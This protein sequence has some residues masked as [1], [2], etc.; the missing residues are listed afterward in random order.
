MEYCRETCRRE[1]N[2][3]KEINGVLPRNLEERGE[4]F[5]KKKWSGV[6]EHD[7]QE[8]PGGERSKGSKGR[9]GV[10]SRNMI[11]AET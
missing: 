4:R 6:E 9:N 8:K 11:R 2:G 10:L 3:W 7:P 5:G 1:V